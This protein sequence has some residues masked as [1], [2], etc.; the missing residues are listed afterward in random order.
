MTSSPLVAVE[1]AQHLLSQGQRAVGG[2][3]LALTALS[4]AVAPAATL[5]GLVAVVSLLYAAVVSH[6]ILLVVRGASERRMVDVP[7]DEA[8]SVPA[9]E[10]PRYSVLVPLYREPEVVAQV[11]GALDRLDYP[12]SRL[13]VQLLL[14]PDDDETLAAVRR[15]RVPS[16]VRVRV[17]PADGPRTKP[18]ACNHGLARATGDVITIYDAEDLPEPLQLRRAAVGL[19]RLPADVACLQARLRYHNADQNL[20]TSWFTNEYDVWFSYYLPGLVAT[21]APVPLGGTSNHLRSEALRSVGGWDDHNVT[22][23]ADLGLRLH[24]HGWR[25]MVLDS[26][27]LEE[28][29]SDFVNWVKQRSRWYKGYLS[30]WLVHSRRPRATLDEQGWSAFLGLHLFVGGT[31]LLAAL[32]PVFW[33]LTGCWLVLGASSVSWLLSGP[34]YYVSLLSWAVGTVAPVYVALYA[35]R[36]HGHPE[37]APRLLLLPVYWVMMS[38]AAVKAVVQ[39]VSCPAYWEKTTHGLDRKAAGRAAA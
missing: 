31:P 9:A 14:E 10:L 7:D 15:A 26:V 30:T 2:S 4:L 22:E 38:I 36:E 39:L 8:R 34:S 27:T 1:S 16:Y 24:R 5:R 18:H 23:D 11:L 29:N 3:L 21:G 19:A 13:E 17:V 20:I 12:R 6:R 28:A 32:N 25:T 35:A 33:L 37:L